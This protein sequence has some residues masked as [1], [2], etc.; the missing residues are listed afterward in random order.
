[1]TVSWKGHEFSVYQRGTDWNEVA[2]LYIFAGLL[3]DDQ[4][5]P[6]WHPFYVG[7]CKTFSGYI[8]THR[9]WS[10]AELLGATHVHAI[11]VKDAERRAEIERDLIQS[12]Q[13][14]LN[15]QLR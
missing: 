6:V 14:P 7:R 15:I 11:T 4:G 3:K 9:K 13:P 10:E 2:S 8:P 5:K 12:Y 1:M